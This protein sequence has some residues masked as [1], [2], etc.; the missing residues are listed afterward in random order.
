MQENRKTRN[1]LWHM[2]ANHQL[3]H[4]SV[5]SQHALN[6]YSALEQLSMWFWY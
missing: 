3:Y 4:E 1:Q 5:F 2:I 6:D